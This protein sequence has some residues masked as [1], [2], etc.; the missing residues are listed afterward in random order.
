LSISLNS[1]VIAAILGIAVLWIAN[2]EG[3]LWWQ[4]VLVVA[5]S[6]YWLSL[7]L[8]FSLKALF[9]FGATPLPLRTIAVQPAS[10]SSFMQTVEDQT[11]RF[12]NP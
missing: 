11:K 1:G 6:P 2:S 8:W 5:I 12:S 10:V 9:G 7:L 4:V 3:S